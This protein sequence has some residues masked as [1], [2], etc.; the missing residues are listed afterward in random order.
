MKQRRGVKIDSSLAI[1]HPVIEVVDVRPDVGVSQYNTLGVTRRAACVN[2]GKNCFGV[3][4]RV[5][6]GFVSAWRLFLVDDHLPG[7]ANAGHGKRRMANEPMWGSVAENVIDLDCREPGVNWN[8]NHTEPTARIH[9]LDA[10]GS[11]R[12]QKRQ[13]IAAFKSRGT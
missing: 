13:P 10:L 3:V 5:G 4:A 9:E 1:V 7:Y 11:V 6:T 12:K 8:H 2:Q